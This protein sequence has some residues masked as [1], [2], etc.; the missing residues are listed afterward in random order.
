MTNDTARK[1]IGSTI[2]STSLTHVSDISDELKITE[3]ADATSNSQASV[4]DATSGQI[5]TTDVILEVSSNENKP[6]SLPI[7]PVPHKH[8][9]SS[10]DDSPPPLPSSEPPE[11][12]DDTGTF[13]TELQS[14]KILT[15]YF[16]TGFLSMD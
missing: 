16:T 4:K 13:N 11:L 15:K 7:L 1:S 9:S 14:G 6:P 10:D 2:S 5:S 8:L 3:K 12:N